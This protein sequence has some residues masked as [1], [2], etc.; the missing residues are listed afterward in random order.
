MVSKSL[1]TLVVLSILSL[2]TSAVPLQTESAMET[3]QQFKRFRGEPIRFGKRVPR[4]P[5]RFGKRA[6]LFEP[7]FD[8]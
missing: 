3:S 6:P 1:V 7:Y 2:L 8:Y 5:I 4:E